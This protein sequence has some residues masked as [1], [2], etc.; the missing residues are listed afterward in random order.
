MTHTLAL[1]FAQ[2]PQGGS[3]FPVGFIIQISLVVAIFYFLL[4]RPQK[5]QRDAHEERL[6]NIRKGDEIVT[7]GGIIGKIEG[8]KETMKD[9]AS[10]KTMEDRV[11]IRSGES[12]LVIERG[13]IARVITE[14]AAAVA[15]EAK[16]TP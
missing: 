15:T 12:R 7:S 11:T 14:P 1:L 13:R 5:K 8:I 4:I 6:R 16:T 2:S 10:Q 3:A 9:G